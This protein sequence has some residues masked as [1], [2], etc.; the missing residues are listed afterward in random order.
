MKIAVCDDEKE[1]RELLGEKITRLYPQ[2]ALIFFA[3]GEEE[4]VFQ[5]FDVGAF[6]YL[7]KPFEDAKFQAVLQKA[8]EQ[9]GEEVRLSAM[10]MVE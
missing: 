5:A 8:V 10:L 1:I 3:S 6:H 2:A 7:V 9:N 4:N